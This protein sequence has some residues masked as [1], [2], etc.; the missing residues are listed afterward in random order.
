M[1]SSTII[2]STATPVRN[3]SLAGV[4]RVSA[5]RQIVLLLGIAVAVAAGFAI[6]MWSQT[7]GFTQLYVDLDVA[8]AADVADA[9][10]TANI[11]Y[12]LNAA[13]GNILVPESS[14]H[15]ARMQL[16]SQGL[17]ASASSGM[18][19]LGEQSGFGTSQFM[20]TARYQH[21][22]EAELGHTIA[23]LGAVREAR[24]HLALPNRSS[25]LRDRE[26]ASA[27]VLVHLFRGRSLESEQATAIVN[28]VAASVPDLQPK[29]VTV[30]DQ[31][32]SLLNSAGQETD[33]Q[34]T[35]QFKYTRRLEETF[36]S[37]IEDLLVPLVGV[38][39]VR[40]EV[41]ADVD[42]TVVE[43]TRESFD[44]ASTV[45]R[46]EQISEDLKTG[47]GVLSGGVPGALSNQ[48][49]E[50]A[51]TP[52]ADTLAGSETREQQNSSRSSIRNF[53]VDR[54][55]SHTRPQAGTIR[56]L[57]VA[58][59][60]DESAP[61]EGAAAAT[62]SD[63]QIAE[64]TSLV[65]EAVGFN[66]ARGDTVVVL[67]GE[68][69]HAAPLAPAAA[70]P[71]W[72]KPVLRDA[73]KQV[74]GAALVLAIAFGVVRPMLKSVVNQEPPPAVSGE[75]LG[76]GGSFPVATGAPVSAAAAPIPAPSY[77]E[78]VAAAKNITGHDPARVA[79][80]V[81]QWVAGDA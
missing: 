45:V 65:R 59:L 11:E 75:Y 5:V 18:A 25:F 28:L 57:S 38:G 55:I 71:F 67:G 9:L 78:K 2:D 12:K 81:K 69:K 8:E 52:P 54:T 46:S 60:V 30:V 43:E 39:R 53:E 13:T 17:P 41:V 32:G 56:R 73:L 36:K 74:L 3:I 34:A 62:L 27:S 42:F 80:V 77:D 15:A 64:Y 29:N 31:Y 66:E 22:L 44:P 72:E 48:P 16:A 24:V 20:E 76:A 37:R 14:L 61:E 35:T 40:A 63:Q 23:S 68:F 19:S 58:V 79:Q 33:A 26:T 4:L 70:P 6:A 21:A 47:N 7:P 1:E 10:R 50:A 51:D 49:P